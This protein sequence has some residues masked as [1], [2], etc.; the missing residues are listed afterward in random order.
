MLSLKAQVHLD[1][2]Y[3]HRA[4]IRALENSSKIN[5]TIDEDVPEDNAEK[6]VDPSSM[7]QLQWLE[8]E[9]IN[10]QNLAK[11]PQQ[12]L[13]NAYCIRKGL[14]RKS[15]FAYN[16]SKYLSKNPTSIL[17][18]AIPETWLFELDHVDYFEEAMNEVYEVERDLNEEGSEHMFIIKPSM[19]NKAAGIKVFNSLEQL[20]AM[21]E[22]PESDEEEEEEEE[23]E[24]DDGREDLS[25]VREWV[26][27][28]YIKHPLLVNGRK[29]HIRAYVLAKSNIQVYLYK[30]MLA[31]FAMKP[32]NTSNLEDNLIHLTNTCI[33]Q[34][35]EGFDEKA[36]VKL[37]WELD[38]PKKDL[39]HLFEQM[40]H[41]LADVFDA[42]TSEMT[43]FQAMPNAF[44]LFGVDFLVDQELNVYFLEA[45]AFPDFKQTGDKLQYIIQELFEA[46]HRVVI[47]PYFTDSQEEVID[48]NLIKVFEK[49]LLAL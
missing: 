29:F 3:T 42:C 20:R 30:P 28:R 13:A 45:N 33:Q 17:K 18:Q 21:F 26:I 25:Q 4:V 16:V 44:E 41:I 14:I 43:T 48:E 12:T 2:P 15:Q 10:W 22:E 47:E 32:Y 11:N 37:F 27:Q 34:G 23:E 7:H 40:K 36:S 19:A 39:N 35:E 1:E 46:T 49:E 9:L 5:W 8:Y 38:L 6:Q 31:L 24:E